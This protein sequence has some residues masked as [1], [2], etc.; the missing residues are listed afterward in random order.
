MFICQ[1]KQ[2][3]QPRLG[4]PHQTANLG[5][6]LLWGLG[7]IREGLQVCCWIKL[8]ADV[9]W[10]QS[11]LHL[12][13]RKSNRSSKVGCRDQQPLPR[14]PSATLEA[15]IKARTVAFW[16]LSIIHFSGKG[17]L[18]HRQLVTGCPPSCPA[19]SPRC[20]SPVWQEEAAEL[21]AYARAQAWSSTRQASG[22]SFAFT[23]H[24]SLS[25]P[26]TI[27]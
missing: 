13:L 24:C 20:A 2:G 10:H 5:S 9:L 12:L 26:T 15:L 6:F 23:P 18:I 17:L 4:K 25:N 7:R 8:L 14:A 1:W 27:N 21:C 3:Q 19:A 16:K 11:R 22:E